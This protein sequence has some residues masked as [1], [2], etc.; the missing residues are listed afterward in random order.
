MLRSTVG[1]LAAVATVMS[2][3]V[4]FAHGDLAGVTI[5]SAALAVGLAAYYAQPNKKKSLK[6]M[7]LRKRENVAS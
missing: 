3:L 4:A 6:P 1:L 7:T 5:T 2:G